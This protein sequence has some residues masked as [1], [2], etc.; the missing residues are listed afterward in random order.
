M[1]NN[2]K[3]LREF[4]APSAQGLHS[5]IAKN[6]SGGKQ[7]PI[8]DSIHVSNSTKSVWGSL[9]ED[10]HLYISDFLEYCGTVK[11][12]GVLQDAI[13]LRLFPFSLLDNARAWLHSHPEGSI[14]TRD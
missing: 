3:T 9:M 12:N 4:A 14:T 8:V 5:S 2:N 7:L 10:P 1:E 6:P 13:R 11:L